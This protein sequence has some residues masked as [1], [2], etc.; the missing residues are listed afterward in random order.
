MDGDNFKLKVAWLRAYF[1]GDGSVSLIKKSIFAKSMNKRGLEEIKTLL[2][3]LGIN[4]HILGPYN[5]AHVLVIN[6]KGLYAKKIGFLSPEKLDKLNLI[7]NQT[8]SGRLLL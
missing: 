7:F 4:S 8:R 3:T 2:K 1:D 6:D 5:G